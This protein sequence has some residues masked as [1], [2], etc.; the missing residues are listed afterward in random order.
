MLHS[1]PGTLPHFLLETGAYVIGASVYWRAAATQ[2]LPPRRGD[3]LAL[4]AGAVC[5]ALI[6]SKLLHIAE[7]LPALWQSSDWS[8]WVGG[9][10]LLGGLLGGTLGVEIVKHHVGWTRP[11][12]DA[13]VPA[14]AV[15]IIIGR[16]GC[17]L[18]GLWDLTYGIPTALPWAWDYGDGVGRHPTA[19]YEMA[20]VALLWAG[21][22]RW[23]PRLPGAS[24]AAFLLGYCVVRFVLEFLKPPF[25]GDPTAT[26]PVALFAGLTAIQWAAV[27][28]GGY[29]AFSLSRRLSPR[30]LGAT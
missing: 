13:W 4:L 18:S 14:L 1:F 5:G 2:P 16:M 9:K 3:R 11:T 15:G 30:T 17:Q 12:G 27:A 21:V 19:L 10:S 22:S 6:G 24:F 23:V 25:G 8:L 7:H 26:L 28:G 20:C 29:F